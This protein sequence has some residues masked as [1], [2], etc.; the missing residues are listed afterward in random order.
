MTFAFRETVVPFSSFEPLFVMFPT[1]VPCGEKFFQSPFRLQ[2]TLLPRHCLYFF[3][4]TSQLLLTKAS[5]F[6]TYFF[7]GVYRSSSGGDVSAL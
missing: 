1:I 4:G 5:P 2:T 6:L 7:K 3:L